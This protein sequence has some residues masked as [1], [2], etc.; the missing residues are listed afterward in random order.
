MF[1][2]EYLDFRSQYCIVGFRRICRN[3]RNFCKN[4]ASTF[5]LAAGIGYRRRF[6]SP[7]VFDTFCLTLVEYR[8][9]CLQSAQGT[10]KTAIG[11]GVY[12]HFFQ[13]TD[14]HAVIQPVREDG[15]QFVEVSRT[16]KGCDLC[17]VLSFTVHNLFCFRCLRGCDS[18][19]E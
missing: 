6:A 3:S 12:H 9:Q 18:A 17:N 14:G 7:I 15:F 10:G 1:F 16:R 13:L 5:V 2:E 4:I 11:V 19:S 8:N